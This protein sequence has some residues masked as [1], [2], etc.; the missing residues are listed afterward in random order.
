MPTL[1]RLTKKCPYCAETIKAEA[2]VC[3]YCGR[4]L[5][6]SDPPEEQKPEASST[7]YNRSTAGETLPWDEVWLRA[8][9]K[10][11]AATF[12]ELLR[13]PKAVSGRA[14]KWIFFGTL[15]GQA[16]ALLMFIAFHQSPRL[17][18]LQK[19]SLLSPTMKPETYACTLLISPFG[20][21]IGLWFFSHITQWFARMFDGK[22]TAAELIYV[23]AAYL[24]PISIITTPLNVIPIV[25][26]VNIFFSFYLMVLELLA[27]K[28]I[29]RFGWGAAIA[30]VFLPAVIVVGVLFAC[31]F[32]LVMEV[33]LNSRFR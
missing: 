1:Q 23:R 18:A 32:F 7:N 10:P 3:R 12:E 22:G 25:A 15:V 2:I 14:Y 30:S 9:T 16:I 4:D 11:S 17:A 31:L 29:N 33:G 21:I 28:T 5:P 24:A 26:Y 27:V 20:A 13:D 19:F 6:S 8:L